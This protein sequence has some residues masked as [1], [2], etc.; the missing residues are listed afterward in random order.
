MSG[1]GWCGV[2]LGTDSPCSRQKG[3]LE[4]GDIGQTR[5]AFFSLPSPSA[6]PSQSPI[7]FSHFFLTPFSSPVPCQLP[8]RCRSSCG[9]R[10]LQDF[11]KFFFLF[12]T[13]RSSEEYPLCC[14]C[15]IQK[16]H[17][18]WHRTETFSVWAEGSF[19]LCTRC[20]RF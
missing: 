6:L 7:F 17:T 14:R 1:G 18:G 4:W 12:F 20:C 13:Q 11:Y 2:I 5:W 19:M 9:L 8:L 15:R 10:F 3:R 16:C